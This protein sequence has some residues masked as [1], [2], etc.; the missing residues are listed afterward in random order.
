MYVLS[1]VKG[2]S[3]TQVV[4]LVLTKPGVSGWDSRQTQRIKVKFLFYCIPQAKDKKSLKILGN[5]SIGW[6][7]RRQTE[8]HSNGGKKN[9]QEVA[10]ENK[11]NRKCSLG[12]KKD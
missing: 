12:G 3:T 11:L 1:V 4:E 9:R 7:I 5:L 10:Q 8:N 6:G 2:S